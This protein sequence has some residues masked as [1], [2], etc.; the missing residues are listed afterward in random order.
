MFFKEKMNKKFKSIN[1][2][3]LLKYYQLN[4]FYYKFSNKLPFVKKIVITLN[5]KSTDFK[6][7]TSTHLALEILFYQKSI[8]TKVNTP[9]ILYKT[10]TGQPI[11]CKI[12]ENHKVKNFELIKFIF[13]MLDISEMNN[14]FRIN[15]K[16]INNL[17]QSI[18]EIY[19]FKKLE[20]Y[21]LLF[22]KLNK[23]S[24]SFLIKSHNK[25]YDENF[26]FTSF[27]SKHNSIGRV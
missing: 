26:Y 13:K 6:L 15:K 11:G 10:K 16:N 7:L 9:N 8:S 20:S 23:L 14:H 25:S 5:Q 18:F 2:N 1:H 12:T 21:Y 22:N 17:T 24:I 27:F 3:K 4:K 19:N